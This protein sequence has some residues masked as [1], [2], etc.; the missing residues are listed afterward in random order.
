MNDL[1]IYLVGGAVRDKLLGLESKDRDWVVVGST[2]EEMINLGFKRV[3]A[4]FPV[5]LHPETHEEYA[6]ART[7]RKQGH[8]YHGFTCDSSPDVTLEDDLRRRDLTI[9]AMALS[10]TGELIDPYNGQTD[11][12]N[13][14]LRHVS[15][16]FSEDPLRVLRVARFAARFETFG[17]QIAQ[18]TLTMMRA[19]AD[20]GELKHLVAERIWQE[21][22]RAL[23]EP[24][25]RTYFE[26]LKKS[27]SLK[28]LFPELEQLFGIPQTAKYHPEVDTGVHTLM[29]LD[30][31]C[32][33]STSPEVRYAT[34][35]HDLGKGLTPKSILPSH[36]GHET[37]GLKLVR[38]MSSRLKAPNSFVELALITCE[39]H[40]HVHRAFEL[41]SKTL[42]KVLKRCD[43]FRKPERFQAFLLCCKADALGRKGFS[44]KSYPQADFFD[45]VLQAAKSVNPQE[46]IQQG[47]KGQK[48]GEAIDAK[49]LDAIS[50]V[51]LSHQHQSLI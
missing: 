47:F 43:A 34:L 46:L 41:K 17:F 45:K 21:T 42:L 3:G 23:K 13:K 40:T 6:L 24:S 12:N 32:R 11:L 25:P 33:I 30:Q 36:H 48:L 38:Q 51:K 50:A 5:F 15:N 20:T 9:N 10:T 4:D 22:Y 44:N 26:V 16:A 8:G 35:T 37:K 14:V 2:P 28:T 49:R 27:N 1:N 19:I 18:E 39:F 31:A 7:E 29:S